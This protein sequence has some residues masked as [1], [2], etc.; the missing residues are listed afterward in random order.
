MIQADDIFTAQNMAD[1]FAWLV[2]GLL[3]ILGVWALRLQSQVDELIKD[4]HE[5]KVYVEISTAKKTDIDRIEG[6]FN[7]IYDR[8]EKKQD[9]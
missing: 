7:R 9:K 6:W 5:Y 2:G 1:V 8:L 3:T 4:L